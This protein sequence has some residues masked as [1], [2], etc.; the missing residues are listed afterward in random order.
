MR[1]YDF[2]G[3]LK[4]EGEYLN[5]KKWNGKKYDEEKNIIYEIKNGKG[6]ITKRGYIKHGYSIFKGEYL[7]GETKGIK[8]EIYNNPE[9]K[10]KLDRLIFGGECINGKKNGKGREYDK[11]FGELIFEGEYLKD[12]KYKGKNYFR[13]KLDYEGEYLFYRK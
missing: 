5:G 13:R 6:I 2:N 11:I 10:G 7:N 12:H 9:L 1:K 4:F 3:N 8:I